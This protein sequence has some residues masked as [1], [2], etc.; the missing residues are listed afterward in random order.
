M[1]DKI[2]LKVDEVRDEIINGICEV[3]KIPSVKSETKDNAPYGEGIR[4]A[5]LKVM[6]ISE[7]LGFETNNFENHIG[8]AQYGKGD[9]Y[10]CAVGHLDVVDVGEGW[11]KPPFSAHTENGIIYS[12]GILDNKGPIMSCLYAMYVLKEID[13]HPNIPIRIIFGCDEESGNFEDLK[14]YLN[15]EKAPLMGFTPDCKYP[16]VYSERGRAI[17]KISFNKDNIHNFFE[18][19]NLYFLNSLNAA[20]SLG[21]NF[22]D[23]EYGKLEIKKY[24]L[25]DKG[26]D[27]GADITISYPFKIDC[28]TIIKKVFEKTKRFVG[29]RAEIENKFFPVRFNKDGFL[30]KSLQYSYEKVSG[31]DG[32]PVTTS[33]GT[34]AKMM[35]NI[36]PFGPSFP[37][38][39]NISHRANEWM[40][41]DDIILNVK[42]YA[43][44]LYRLSK[45]QKKM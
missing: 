24:I 19:I 9:D 14:F 22:E 35:P 8:Y 44:A 38:Q 32:T 31:L 5:L 12:R 10:V 20:E 43:I 39:K 3:V 34:Y 1:E 15:K 25:W 45:Q 2:L 37:G 17:L 41:I 13:F 7:R 33:G 11:R 29:I 27:V 40:S 42:I 21:I 23:K 28:E 18:F 6:D 4:D 26:C 36:V 30:V 16:V